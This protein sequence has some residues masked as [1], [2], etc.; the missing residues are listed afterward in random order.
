MALPLVTLPDFDFLSEIRKR[1]FQKQVCVR[2]NS[3][4]SCVVLTAGHNDTRK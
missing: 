1:Q 4:A 3:N 2:C